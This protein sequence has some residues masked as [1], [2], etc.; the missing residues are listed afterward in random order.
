MSATF[1]SGNTVE[2]EMP[3]AAAPAVSDSDEATAYCD[4]H[5]IRLCQVASHGWLVRTADHAE[6][7]G[8]VLGCIEQ[9]LDG[10]EL[11]ELGGGFRWSTFGTLSEAVAQLVVDRRQHQDS[12]EDDGSVRLL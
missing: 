12:E 9:H 1:P 8:A 4:R 3:P 7:A 10:F 6:G 11:M 5:D 2:L